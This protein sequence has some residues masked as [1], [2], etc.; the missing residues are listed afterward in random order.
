MPIPIEQRKDLF[1]LSSDLNLLISYR[2]ALLDA[3]PRLWILIHHN[4]E[5]NNYG[6]EVNNSSGS[7][8]SAQEIEEVRE[9]L[10][11]CRSQSTPVIKKTRKKKDVS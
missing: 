5:T 11:I 10:R 9:V 7:A 3:N 1:E 8:C 4:K 2:K 6:L